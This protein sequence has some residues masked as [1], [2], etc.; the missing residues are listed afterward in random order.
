MG[1]CCSYDVPRHGCKYYSTVSVQFTCDVDVVVMMYRSSAV[2]NTG[3]PVQFTVVI[4][5]M[6]YRSTG[7]NNTAELVQLTCDVAVVVMTY[8]SIGVNNTGNTGTI[9]CCC[10]SYDVPQYWCK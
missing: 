8:R 3:L 1:Y 9:Y 5:V 10:C 6:M 2:N 7:V 4:V